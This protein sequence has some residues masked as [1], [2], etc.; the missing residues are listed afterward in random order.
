[1]RE[2]NARAA[3]VRRAIETATRA[4]QQSNGTWKIVGGKDTD[5]EDLDVAV[6]VGRYPICIVTVF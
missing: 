2:R 5:E 3:D 4:V 6:D 1:M